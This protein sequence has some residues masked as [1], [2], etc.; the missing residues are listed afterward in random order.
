IFGPQEDEPLDAV[1][2]CAALQAL[3]DQV[4]AHAAAHGKAAKSLDEVAAG[5]LAVANEAMCRPIRALTQ[6]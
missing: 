1:G 3:T 6:M 4:N 2:A 5:F